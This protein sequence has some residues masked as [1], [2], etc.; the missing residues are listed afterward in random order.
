MTQLYDAFICH[1]S[2]DKD[3]F[4]RPLATALRSFG[5]S[6]WFETLCY[7]GR[8]PFSMLISNGAACRVRAAINASKSAA[9]RASRGW[10]C[11]QQQ[12]ED[13]DSEHAR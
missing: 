1:A 11:D 8:Q 4:V 9:N 3:A 12:C 7:P 6:V 5:V 2:E 10:N 13:K